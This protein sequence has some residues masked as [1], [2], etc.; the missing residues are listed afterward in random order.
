MSIGLIITDGFG[1]GTQHGTIAG[2]VL[3]GFVSSSTPPPGTGHQ[4]GWAVAITQSTNG[5][6]VARS[7]YIEGTSCV[8]VLDVFDQAGTQ[9]T[10]KALRYRIDDTGSGAPILGW[11]VIPVPL[12]ETDVVI[13]NAQNALIS[14]TLDF[15]TH[16]VLFEITDDFDQLNYETA[17]FE[18]IRTSGS[19]IS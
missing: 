19:A 7:A 17:L 4:F 11:T 3:D 10:P 8:A 14:L 13:N 9:F 5:L 15:E 18:I 16:Q 6:P 2:I 12:I 1:N